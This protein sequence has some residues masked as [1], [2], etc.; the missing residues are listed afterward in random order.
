MTKKEQ[1]EISR[2]YLIAKI[3]YPPV[4]YRILTV[5]MYTALFLIFGW[6]ITLATWVILELAAYA[7]LKSKLKKLD[8]MI[9]ELK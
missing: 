9:K 5:I 3:M 6:K 4:G 2:L 8:N 1:L 7:V